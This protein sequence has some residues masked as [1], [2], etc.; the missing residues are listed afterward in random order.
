MSEETLQ[1]VLEQLL[2]EL[3]LDPDPFSTALDSAVKVLD[4]ASQLGGM[5]EE[6]SDL[7]I[8]CREKLR[9]LTGI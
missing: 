5:S 9:E 4:F 7:L 1:Q 6:E 8:Q 3:K 2:E